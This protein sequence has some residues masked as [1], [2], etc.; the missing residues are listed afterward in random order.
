MLRTF[1]SSCSGRVRS[2]QAAD[3]VLSSMQDALISCICITRK[4]IFLSPNNTTVICV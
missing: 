4:I 2:E 1:T 3:F